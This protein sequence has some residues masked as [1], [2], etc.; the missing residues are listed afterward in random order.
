METQYRQGKARYREMETRYRHGK[1]ERREMET[2]YRYRE[3]Q[4]RQARGSPMLFSGK[5]RLNRWSSSRES[6]ADAG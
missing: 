2:R 1:T 5:E 3:I 4:E 6:I